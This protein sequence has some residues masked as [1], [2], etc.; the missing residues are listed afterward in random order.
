MKEKRRSEVMKVGFLVKTKNV[1]KK[2]LD[3]R[4][5]SRVVGVYV[6]SLTAMG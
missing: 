2:D 1:E 6:G 3:N 4:V 5:R